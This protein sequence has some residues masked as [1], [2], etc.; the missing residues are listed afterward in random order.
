MNKF[1]MLYESLMNEGSKGFFATTNPEKEF[2]ELEKYL[3][4]KYPKL[5]IYTEKDYN[6][7]KR[8]VASNA[9]NNK[10][11]VFWYKKAGRGSEFVLKTDWGKGTTV[12]SEADIEAEISN[13]L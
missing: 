3:K 13:I 9:E 11:S 8:V 5:N 6:V 2:G 10:L 12:N 7:G 1:D 4:K